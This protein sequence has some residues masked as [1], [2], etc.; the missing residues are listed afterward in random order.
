M[1]TITVNLALSLI[2][3]YTFY[4]TTTVNSGAVLVMNIGLYVDGAAEVEKQEGMCH[5]SRQFSIIM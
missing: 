2:Y 3:S 1:T 4:C 5:M